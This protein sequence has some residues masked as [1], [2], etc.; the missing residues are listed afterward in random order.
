[1]QMQKN[2]AETICSGS[3][4][5]RGTGW[6]NGLLLPS[7]LSYVTFQLQITRIFFLTCKMQG[8]ESLQRKGSVSSNYFYQ[9][10]IYSNSATD[11]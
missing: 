10:E 6:G 7:K 9:F 5:L 11:G 3:L 1:M 8:R 4:T 2:G